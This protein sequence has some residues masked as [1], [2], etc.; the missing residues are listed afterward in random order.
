MTY[1]GFLI[2]GLWM[3]AAAI[4]IIPAGG[5]IR[6]GTT[7][8]QFYLLSVA[9]AYFALSWRKGGQTLGMKAW[10]VQLLADAGTVTWRAT[11]VRFFVALASVICGGLGFFWS[12]FHPH[13]ATWHDL[14]SGTRLIV[15]PERPKSS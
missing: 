2:V 14:A 5:E 1:D 12:L 3:A 13:R 8:F 6:P 7:I 10:R 9:W 15:R 11:V 4:V